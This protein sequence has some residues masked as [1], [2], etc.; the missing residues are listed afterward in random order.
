MFDFELEVACIIGTDGR[1]LHP[2]EP[3]AP[4]RGL[5]DLL[6]ATITG[7]AKRI[8]ELGMAL[9]HTLLG[10]ASKPDPG[11]L[12]RPSR[13]RPQRCAG[14]TFGL[15]RYRSRWRGDQRSF[16]ADLRDDHRHQCAVA[17]QSG[18][19]RSR[20]QPPSHECAPENSDHIRQLNSSHCRP[21]DFCRV[22]GQEL[23]ASASRGGG[24]CAGSCIDS[25]S[26][27]M[28]DRR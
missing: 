8:R 14:L 10:E 22:K 24:G 23:G 7:L 11:R 9:L 20:Q 5:H 21:A 17:N 6:E 1:N 12:R 3:E 15:P 27:T 2:D 19:S 16:R 26:A 25:V 4:H 18:V 13:T 28:C